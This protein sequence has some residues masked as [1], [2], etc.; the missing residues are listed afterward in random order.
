MEGGDYTWLNASHTT[1]VIRQ[2][3]KMGLH[4]TSS[5]TYI[6]NEVDFQLRNI[7]QPSVSKLQIIIVNIKVKIN[8]DVSNNI[9]LFKS[10]SFG[11]SLALDLVGLWQRF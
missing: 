4:F 10:S 9:N 3:P 5:T 8:N 7:H 6:M 2:G 1:T 11:F